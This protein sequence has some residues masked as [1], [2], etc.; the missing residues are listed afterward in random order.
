MRQIVDKGNKFSFRDKEF[1]QSL[2]SSCNITATEEVSMMRSSLSATLMS[3]AARRGD[4]AWLASLQRDKFDCTL[5]DYDDRTPLHIAAA[6]NEMEIATCLLT[7]GASVHARDRAGGTPLYD[8]LK[9]RHWDLAKLLVVTG[10][11][12]ITTDMRACVCARLTGHFY[13]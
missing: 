11:A 4:A 5:A 1:V 7:W 9:G 10:A 3:Y 8:A 12:A 13:R 2:L 6:E